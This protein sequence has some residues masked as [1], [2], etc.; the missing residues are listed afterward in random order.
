M[1]SAPV[2]T[3]ATLTR[4]HERASRRVHDQRG[5]Y[6]KPRQL[7]CGEACTLQPRAGLRA[8]DARSLT[9]LPRGADDAERRT[10][11]RRCERSGVAVCEDAAGV[12]HERGSVAPDSLVGLDVLLPQL[13]CEGEDACGRLAGGAA[14]ARNVHA[15]QECPTEVDGGGARGGHQRCLG[16]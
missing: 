6:A 12:R 16:V 5:R 14:H 13:V 15:P 10:V 11:A 1:R 4:R 9:G 8:E 2:T 3:A 7:P